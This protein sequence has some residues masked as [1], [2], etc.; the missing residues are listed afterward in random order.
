VTVRFNFIAKLSHQPLQQLAAL[1][2]QAA[3]AAI[4]LPSQNGQD[5]VELFEEVFAIHGNIGNS[6]CYRPQVKS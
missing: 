2:G 3:L 4:R 1:F 6:Y 5:F